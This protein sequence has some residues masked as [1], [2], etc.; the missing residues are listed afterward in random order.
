MKL[1]RSRRTKDIEKK[2][3]IPP[4]AALPE[5]SAARKAAEAPVK[6]SRPYRLPDSVTAKP[7]PVVAAE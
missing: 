2:F 7:K 6:S 4:V 1:F 5:P 3:W